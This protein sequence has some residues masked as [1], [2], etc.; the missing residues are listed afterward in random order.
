[1]ILYHYQTCLNKMPIVPDLLELSESD[2]NANNYNKFWKRKYRD[3]ILVEMFSV[4]ERHHVQQI[5][6]ERFGSKNASTIRFH[7]EKDQATL[8][9]SKSYFS[10]Y[11]SDTTCGIKFMSEKS[12]HWKTG[13]FLENHNFL[14][15]LK[16]KDLQEAIHGGFF[17]SLLRYG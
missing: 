2:P 3:K 6:C 12:K 14:S 9:E 16:E 13:K 17:F 15:C 8:Q 7:T 10:H 1:M 4:S 5:I 11:S